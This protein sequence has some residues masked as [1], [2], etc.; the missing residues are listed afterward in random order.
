MAAFK[1]RMRQ[2]M[3]Y[4]QIEWPYEYKYWQKNW[5]LKNI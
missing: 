1:E 3:Q 5:G 2:L 4:R